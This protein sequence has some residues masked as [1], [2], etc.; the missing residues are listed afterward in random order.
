MTTLKGYPCFV[1]FSFYNKT[2][3]KLYYIKNMLLQK[4]TK[5]N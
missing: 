3:I 1:F 4:D 5:L 2:F